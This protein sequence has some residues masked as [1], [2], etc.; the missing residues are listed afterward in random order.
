MTLVIDQ[1]HV[2]GLARSIDEYGIHS[3]LDAIKVNPSQSRGQD[4]CYI[5]IDSSHRLVSQ[6]LFEL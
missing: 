4:I 1:M 5:V 2:I 6:L 3:T